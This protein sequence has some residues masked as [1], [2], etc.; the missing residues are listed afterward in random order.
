MEANGRHTRT[1]DKLCL[2]NYWWY[3]VY[4]MIGG[5]GSNSTLAYDIYKNKW[6]KYSSLIH[7]RFA[8][9]LGIVGGVLTV[10]GGSIESIESTVKFEQLHGT[11]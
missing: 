9:G 3:V 1:K 5:Y 7:E 2:W 8:G 6:H 11:G 10:F 4:Y